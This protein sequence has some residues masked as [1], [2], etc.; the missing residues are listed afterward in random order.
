MDK[1]I[2][3]NFFEYILLRTQGSSVQE[4]TWQILSCPP[5]ETTLKLKMVQNRK[6]LFSDIVQQV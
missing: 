6:Q 2:N 4:P 5:V 3:V 1:A